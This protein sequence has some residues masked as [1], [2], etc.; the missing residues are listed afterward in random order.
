METCEEAQFVGL[1][2]GA[3][4]PQG[5]WFRGCTFSSCD[6]SEASFRS[7][8]LTDCSFEQCDLS[9][10]DFTDALLHSVTFDGC[11]LTGIDFGLLRHDALGLTATFEACDL[12]L[13]S[14]R[15]LDL[16]GCTFRSCNAREAE[17]LGCDLRGVELVETEL[18]SAAFE[19]NDLRDADMRGARNYVL[20]PIDNRVRGMRVDMVG[21]IGLLVGLNVRLE[22]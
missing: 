1:E 16:R 19:G 22:G 2:R 6:L 11:R 5:K 20:S 9:L 14:F 10:A 4:E 8:H 12:T 15:K 13:A 7:A 18:A 21:G 3:I 17:F